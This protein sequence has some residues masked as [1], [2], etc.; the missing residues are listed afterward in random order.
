MRIGLIIFLLT[1]WMVAN[2]QSNYI[3]EWLSQENL[4]GASVGFYAVD[5][6]SGEELVSQN[7]NLS[8]TPASV[9]KIITTSAALE[10]LG[11]DKQFVTSLG[12]TGTIDT[13]NKVLNGDI[14]IKGGG[15]PC[16]GSHRFKNHY[17]D[18]Y[19]SWVEQIKQLGVDSVNGDIIGDASYFSGQTVPD[20]WIWGDLGNYYGAAV[21]GLSVYENMTHVSFKSGKV[22]EETNIIDMNPKVDG[23]TFE[24]NVEGRNTS[25]DEAYFYGAPNQFNRTVEG[26]IPANRSDFKVK[27]SIP[28]P[29]LL[30]A[31]ELKER[32]GKSGIKS[33]S[34]IAV[35]RNLEAPLFQIN[36]IK[37]PKLSEIVRLTNM[38]S[39]NLYAEHL[40]LHLA[41]EKSNEVSFK[42]GTEVVANFLK[43]N[44]VDIKRFYLNDGSGLSRFNAYSVK[45]LVGILQFIKQN[46]GFLNSLPIAGK[47]GTLKN[48][49]KGTLAENNL[50]A[51]SGY[52]T[53]VRSYAGYATTKNNKQIAFS[54]IVN[55]YSG[56]AYS[57]K[58]KIEEILVTFLS[59]N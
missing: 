50:T 47:S 16:F 41:K 25:R 44:G 31:S 43:N 1:S 7:A 42:S 35:N 5:L 21:S 49:F 24:N 22:G 3:Q 14:I 15:D 26:G 39:I 27:S 56:S 54:I 17:G 55:N 46:E 6:L 45:H 11:A 33:K 57:M 51:K 37:S 12:Y 28:N 9:T 53:R 40:L 8:L 20:T 32:L 59:N 2:A 34:A 38:H 4:K 29:A 58:K 30:V 13:L 52:M 19:G 23:L 48:M 36:K 18:F 10:I